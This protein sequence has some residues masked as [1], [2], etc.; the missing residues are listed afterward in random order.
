MDFINKI[1]HNPWI[2]AAA[3]ILSNIGMEYIKED[4]SDR[5]KN[6][7]NTCSLRK[8]YLFALIYTTTENIVISLTATL[9]FAILV[10]MG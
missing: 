4:L 9:I 8:L 2:L 10:H 6:V 1:E 5:Q 7:L 3:V